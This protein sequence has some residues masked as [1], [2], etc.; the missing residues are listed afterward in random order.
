MNGIEV[1]GI[2]RAVAVDQDTAALVLVTALDDAT[3]SLAVTLLSPDVEF[4]SSADLLLLSEETGRPYHLLAESDVFGYVRT[5]QLDR[6]IGRVDAQ[7]LEALSALRTG[8]A[9][10]HPVGGPPVGGR[11]DPRWGFKLQELERL[12]GLTADCTR[13]LIDGRGDQ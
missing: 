11:S 9:V 10:D 13:E 6:L 8:D 7:V 5:T 12:Q 4:G 3:E 1:G 2:Y